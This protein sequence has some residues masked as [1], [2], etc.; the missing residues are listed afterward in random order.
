ME[1]DMGNARRLTFNPPL[2]EAEFEGFCAANPGL[3]IDRDPS[4]VIVVRRRR[5]GRD[6]YGDWLLSQRGTI[7]SEID[8]D[9]DERS[10]VRTKVHNIVQHME[11]LQELARMPLMKTIRTV[12]RQGDWLSAETVSHAGNWKS[13]GRIFS[14]ILDGKEYFPRYEFN[15]LYQPLP[16]IRDILNA[17]GPVDDPW[18]IAVWMHFPNGWIIEPGPEGP[19]AVAPR[20]ALDRPED[21]LNALKK[22][23]ESYIA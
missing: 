22:R 11:N 7:S 19:K 1:L 17:F 12:F 3:E 13:Q 2:T 6:D 5:E 9:D 21:I 10:S 20:D 18:K 8:L 15:A 23:Q 16:V 4:G 14:V